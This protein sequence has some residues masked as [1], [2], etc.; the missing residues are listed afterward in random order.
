MV[1]FHIL[2]L[3]ISLPHIHVSLHAVI[4]VG[5]W[6]RGNLGLRCWQELAPVGMHPLSIFRLQ[7]VPTLSQHL[8]IKWDT[9]TKK[10]DVDMVGC[11][12]CRVSCF[13]EYG[14][15]SN[16]SKNHFSFPLRFLL[17]SSF[18]PMTSKTQQKKV[19][20]WNLSA[21]S[22]AWWDY[23]PPSPEGPYVVQGQVTLPHGQIELHISL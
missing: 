6:C 15:V 20:Q 12:S 17:W 21:M 2:V 16:R 5:L 10:I 22:F 14:I 9:V 23:T 8:E 4:D 19:S 1:L 13:W 18:C 11:M 7:S 3:P